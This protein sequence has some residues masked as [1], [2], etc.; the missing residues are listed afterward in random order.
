[1]SAADL[2]KDAARWNKVRKGLGWVRFG[3][4]LALLP[5]IGNVAVAVYC[6]HRDSKVPDN[7]ATAN[8]H[9]GIDEK[10][11]MA[12]L[13]KPNVLNA[14]AREMFEQPE[15]S[16]EPGLVEKLGLSL[17]KELEIIYLYG[18]PLLAFL[19]VLF[20]LLGCQRIPRS[21]HTR[22]VALGTLFFTFVAFAGF[23]AYIAPHV[24]SIFSLPNIPLP[25]ETEQIG[26][27]V[28]YFVGPL[29]LIWLSIY[30][31]QAS[32]PLNSTR[33][34]RDLA[35]AISLVVLAIA[36]VQIGNLYFPLLVTSPKMEWGNLPVTF[37]IQSAVYVLISALVLLQMIGLAG[38]I[39]RA[40]SRWR[41]EHVGA[42]P[43]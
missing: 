26:R 18:I 24:I 10:E 41:A 36:G 35:Q 8:L 39:R 6:D 14:R 2:D 19:I 43:I 7:F 16:K 20:G 28:F 29:A 3:L 38:G 40:I 42:A 4:L 32:V 23:V 1:M 11:L 25:P 27:T 31:C 21:A 17:W 33:T 30:L 22:G 9:R 34:P 12:A 37:Q 5:S 15:K 13:G